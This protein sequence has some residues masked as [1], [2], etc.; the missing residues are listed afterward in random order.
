M[1]PPGGL[2]GGSVHA[3]TVCFFCQKDMQAQRDRETVIEGKK[4]IGLEMAQQGQGQMDRD[5]NG[6]RNKALSLHLFTLQ[7]QTSISS[8]PCLHTTEELGQGQTDIVDCEKGTEGQEQKEIV[9]CRGSGTETEGQGYSEGKTGT[10][11]RN[12]DRDR[13][14]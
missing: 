7:L 2:G 8:L 14:R 3:L 4:V 6:D 10:G 5:R 9:T 1:P 13:N 12:M 11:Q